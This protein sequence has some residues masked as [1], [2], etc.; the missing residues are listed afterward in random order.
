M[1]ASPP[2]L[3]PHAIPIPALTLIQ[4]LALVRR[5]TGRDFDKAAILQT[6]GSLSEA[7]S[8]ALLVPLLHLLDQGAQ[9]FGVPGTEIRITLSLPLVLAAFVVL[10]ILRSLSL[11]RK[12]AFNARVTF[13]FA[14]RMA[15]RLFAALAATRWSVVSRWRM[16]DMTHAVT[17]D[18]DRLLQTINL[19][20]SLVQSVA[21]TIILTIL[22]LILSWQM[23]MLAGVVG[24]ALLMLTLSGR[25]RTIAQGQRLMEARQS[26]FR[27]TDEFFNGLRTAKAFG[28]EQRHVAAM[29]DVLADIRT[30]HVGFMAARARSSTIYQILTATALAGFAWFALSI[31]H[32]GTA[33]MIALIFLYMRLAP[34]I[35]SLH[36][37]AQELHSQMGG[38]ATMLAMLDTAESHAESDAAGEGLAPPLT[39]DMSF[40]DVSFRYAGA[41]CA[42]LSNID[43]TIAAGQ[44]TAL[45]GPTG[46]GKSTLVDLMLGLAEPDTGSIAVDGIVLDD[47]MRAAWQKRV[48]YVPQETFL[49]NASVGDN[50]RLADE[51]ACDEALWAALRLADAATFVRALPGGLDHPLGDRGR[52]L[53]GGERQRLA[54]A[55][56]LLRKP[57]LLILDE[58][59]SALDAL[60]QKRV[61]QAM[62]S[63][64]GTMTIILV[65]HRPSMVKMADHVIV[66]EAGQ[67]SSEGRFADLMVGSA[68]HVREIVDAEGE[69]TYSPSHR[70]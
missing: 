19:L 61:S 48:A 34:R 32:L 5:E 58:A 36:S 49:F 20:L 2:E 50:L 29:T 42:A 13:G 40:S 46:S 65:A 18:S 68:G 12:E 43:L 28:L 4:L 26:Q 22:S 15:G 16:A 14:E 6:L 30:S 23:T 33:H 59:T 64:R 3:D 44:I 1:P 8:V 17:G 70:S 69:F 7:L 45:I 25:K 35:I 66:L 27:I 11:E 24:M 51:Q 63:L 37:S 52:G 39:R 53:S 31:A 9:V 21:V 60:S 67:V 38:V 41:E 54:I 55:R 47:G 10:I 56:A 62:E 57:D